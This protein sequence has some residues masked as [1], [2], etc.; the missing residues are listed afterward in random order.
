MHRIL[1]PAV[2]AILVGALFART[3]TT[4]YWDNRVGCLKQHISR[5]ETSAKKHRLAHLQAFWRFFKRDCSS[6]HR[7]RSDTSLTSTLLASHP[8]TQTNSRWISAHR[9]PHAGLLPAKLNWYATTIPKMAPGWA[10]SLVGNTSWTRW[11]S[12]VIPVPP[13]AKSVLS[14]L[15]PRL[16]LS[17]TPPAPSLPKSYLLSWIGPQPRPKAL[18][19]LERY[20]SRRTRFF[21]LFFTD[22]GQD[23]SLSEYRVLGKTV[24]SGFF[25]GLSC[26]SYVR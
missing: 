1:P 6:K 25:L 8:F 14:L 19:R 10:A 18:T 11:S 21:K 23:Y 13:V 3:G 12:P 16:S 5:W 22:D 9:I 24:P 4:N 17:H 2:C 15:R 20:F 7:A 26:R